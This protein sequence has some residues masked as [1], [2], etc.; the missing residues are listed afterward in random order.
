[1]VPLSGRLIDQLSLE[2]LRDCL[3][4]DKMILKWV[5]RLRDLWREG[6]GRRQGRTAGDEKLKGWEI[7][8]RVMKGWEGGEEE[9]EGRE[10]EGMERRLADLW[11]FKIRQISKYPSCWRCAATPPGQERNYWER[12]FLRAGRFP[13][14]NSWHVSV[15]L[16]HLFLPSIPPF[17]SFVVGGSLQRQ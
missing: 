4:C 9:R 13:D 5:V 3:H 17:L 6:G 1:M 14:F 10:D 11:K 12:T 2:P 7:A 15:L 16:S 8:W